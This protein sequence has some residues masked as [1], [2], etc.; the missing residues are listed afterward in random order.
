MDIEVFEMINRRR[1]R[2]ISENEID[3]NRKGNGQD[4]LAQGV[5]NT[6]LAGRMWPA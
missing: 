1:E 6:R 2:Q 4:R 5:S 3:N